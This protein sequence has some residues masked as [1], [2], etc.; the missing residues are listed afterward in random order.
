MTTNITLVTFCM[1]K[2]D[3]ETTCV[4]F[5]SVQPRSLPGV[6][7]EHPWVTAQVLDFKCTRH[8]D[9]WKK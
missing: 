6:L 3:Q 4:L 7:A 8:L 5:M 9:M 1:A 2:H